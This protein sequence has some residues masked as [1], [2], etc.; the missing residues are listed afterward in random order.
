MNLLQESLWLTAAS[1]G[2]VWLATSTVALLRLL[3]AHRRLH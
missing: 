1:L 3:T 2:L